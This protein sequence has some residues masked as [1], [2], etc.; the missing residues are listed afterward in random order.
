MDNPYYYAVDLAAMIYVHSVTMCFTNGTIIY[1]TIT[2]DRYETVH[3]IVISALFDVSIV[4][5]LS[6]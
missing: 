2:G 1:S 6:S 5:P 3:C 4:E